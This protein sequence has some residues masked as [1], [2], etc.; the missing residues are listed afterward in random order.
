MDE[1]D[2]LS[3]DKDDDDLTLSRASINKMIKELVSILNKQLCY[4]IMLYS[5]NEILGSKLSSSNRV[6]RTYF[7]LLYRIYTFTKF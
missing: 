2:F 5:F 6:Q 7:K 1:D 3:Q 4:I